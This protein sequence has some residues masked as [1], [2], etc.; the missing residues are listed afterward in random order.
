[1]AD[2]GA[3]APATVAGDVAPAQAV[4]R[5]LVYYFAG[6]DTR[7]ARHYH[8][9]YQ[10]GA[11]AQQAVDACRYEVGPLETESDRV[12][13]WT[14]GSDGPEGP[15]TTRYRFMAWND[16]VRTHWPATPWPLLPRMPAFY[17]RFAACGALG[18]TWRIAR[19]FAWMVLAPLV[20]VTAALA[21]SLVAAALAAWAVGRLAPQATGAALAAGIAGGLGM[22]ALGIA[23]GERWRVFWLMRAW[24]FLWS[25]IHGRLPE[26]GQRCDAFAAQVD[27]D[28]GAEAVDEV[29][30]IGHSA[31]TMTALSVAARWLARRG[32]AGPGP[33]KLVTLGQV[34]PFFGLVPGGAWYRDEMRHVADSGMLWIDYTAPSDPLCYAL[35]DARTAC[36]LPVLAQHRY[37][38]KSS[39]FDR[40]FEPARYATLRRD[41]FRIH[42]QYLMAT[43]R[44][45]D[46]SYFR[47]TAGPTALELPPDPARA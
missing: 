13:A 10:E 8:A 24:P 31:G 35:V 33:V 17:L 27:A 16:I 4:R 29:L 39:R 2:T 32:S 9:L 15:V 42:F 44:P 43:E 19:P 1:V 30:L 40:M 3:A 47:M 18:R 12:A 38:A 28:L 26:I 23:H 22:F 36:G 14:I 25:W 34:H 5:R 20:Q 46:N 7:S 37:R 45:V 6:F 21:V 11:A 41:F